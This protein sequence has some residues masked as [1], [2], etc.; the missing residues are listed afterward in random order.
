MKHLCPY[1]DQNYKSIYNFYN[2][3]KNIVVQNDNCVIKF[4]YNKYLKLKIVYWLK[5]TVRY[6]F[7]GK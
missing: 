2:K 7:N 4:C 5:D 6:D 1:I 3:S